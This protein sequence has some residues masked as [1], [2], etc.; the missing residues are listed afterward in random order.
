MKSKRKQWVLVILLIIIAFI[1]ALFTLPI[2]LKTNT[3]SFYSN[4]AGRIGNVS[5][6]MEEFL[7]Y[8]VDVKNGYETQ[9]GT[10]IWGT[11]TQNAKGEEVT[12]ETLAKEDTF[13]QIRLVKA[14][15][16]LANDE[17]VSI[18]DE[19][20]AVISENASDYYT[21]L[22]EDETISNVMSLDVIEQ[23]F[24]ESY[25]AN[26]VYTI[27]QEEIEAMNDDEYSEYWSN[28]LKTYYPNFDYYTDINWD[29]LNTISYQSENI[30]EE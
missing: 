19:E 8:S 27:H 7:L 14:M 25:L 17:N 6:S 9:Y 2:K 5:I 15:C 23:Y 20:Q 16:L 29:L 13:E 1:I 11:K 26:K 28:I 18:S 10:E 21:L 3:T 4:E 12:F 24:Y 30:K 22:S